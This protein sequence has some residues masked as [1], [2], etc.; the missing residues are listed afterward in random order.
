MGWGKCFVEANREMRGRCRVFSLLA[1][2]SIV[3]LVSAVFASG[4]ISVPES[5]LRTL[6]FLGPTQG[7][8]TE[9]FVDPKWYIKDY[10]LAPVGSTFTVHINISDVTG[11]FTWQINLTF[12]KAVLNVNKITASEF[13][14]RDLYNQT[15]SE[16]LGLVINSTDN[17]KGVCAFSE[18]LLGSSSGVSDGGL[19]GR[20]VSVKFLVVGYGTTPLTISKTGNLNA[21]LLNSAG[22]KIDFTEIHG[23]FDN[24]A[25]GD[26]TGP[27]NPVGS[28]KYPPD[29]T[30]DGRDLIY[31][32]ANFGS[33]NPVADFTGPENPVGSGTYPPDGV[34]DGRDL[35][36]MG[37][38]F[39]RSV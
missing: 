22:N 37:A 29:R 28:G 13:L 6:G 12:N 18:S 1:T 20:L 8:G 34:V 14:A 17:S 7:G 35:I 10:L 25:F 39:G 27:E 33:S 15:S 23:Y 21:T 4:M 9:V 26:I 32:G 3:V 2:L 31:L 24:R 19:G 5:A 16:V 38:N 11:L 36:L 30:V